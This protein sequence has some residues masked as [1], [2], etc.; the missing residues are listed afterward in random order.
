MDWFTFFLFLV[1]CLAAASTGGLFPP[2]E[3]YRHLKKSRLN[4]PDWLFPVAWTVLYIVIAFVG[5][6]IAILAAGKPYAIALWSLQITLNTIWTPVFFG[7]RRISLAMVF[8]VLLWISVFAMVLSYAYID[9]IC[10]SLL[11]PYLIWVSF[12]AFLNFQV[13]VLNRP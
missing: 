12:A 13:L 1:T 10:A 5:M 8:M 11:V 6:R 3:W 4:P 7:L 9:L 2:D